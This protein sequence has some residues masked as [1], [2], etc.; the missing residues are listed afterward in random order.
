[1]KVSFRLLALLWLA[2]LQLFAQERYVLR[3]I[4]KDSTHLYGVAGVLLELYQH[5][6]L[7]TRDF[8]DNAG[9]FRLQV[10][11]PPPYQL[12]VKSGFNTGRMLTIS[13]LDTAITIK[14]PAAEIKAQEVVITAYR[15][16]SIQ[17]VTQTKLHEKAIKEWYYGADIPTLLQFT[18]SINAYS[19]AG[20]GIGYSYF[21]LRG[22]D[23][24]RINFSINGI[25]VNDPENQGVFFNNFADLASSARSLQVVR[26]VG[27]STNGTSAFGGAIHLHTKEPTETPA[28][29]FESGVGSFGSARMVVDYNTGRLAN[30]MAFTGRF[31]QIMSDG[32]RRHSGT[33]IQSY[34][35][36]GAKYGKRSTLRLHAF[37]GSTNSQLAYIGVTAEEMLR[38][39]RYNPITNG[40]KDA[41]NQHFFQLQYDLQLSDNLQLAISPYH[42]R[43]NAPKFQFTFPAEWQTPFSYFNMPPAI[44]GAD[45]I[46]TAGDMLVAY[47]LKQQLYGAYTNLRLSKERSESILGVHANTFHSDHF[48]QHQWGSI[49]PADIKPGHLVYFN[50]GVK[51]EFSVFNKTTHYLS[52]QWLIFGDLQ[53]R[54]AQF[55]YRERAMLYRPSY[56]S[57][58]PMQ[59]SFFNPKAGIRFFAPNGLSSYA[60]LGLTRREPTR[61]DYFQDDFATREGI[62]RDDIKPEQV[63]NLETGVHWSNAQWRI[64]ANLFYMQF[65]NQII[66]SGVLNQ[67]GTP[68]NTNVEHSYRQGV[69]LEL[70]YRPAPQWLL[71]HQSTWMQSR[72]KKITQYYFNEQFEQIPVSFTNI[73]PLLSPNV[74]AQQ[75]LRYYPS[76]DIWVEAISRY[77]SRQY[78]DNSMSNELSIPAYWVYEARLHVN[79]QQLIGASGLQL[80]LVCNN[81]L[82]RAYIPWGSVAAFS[83]T[84]DAEGKTSATPLYFPAATRNWFVT[85]SWRL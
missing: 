9:A 13:Q 76:A 29:G 5:D 57:V 49:L 70:S 39:R 17:P 40:E 74:I 84:I 73:T 28:F 53:W 35:L 41:F 10:K 58:E 65:Y 71:T 20:N 72:I 78:L 44:Q 42:V 14:L 4:V 25:P 59:W 51:N 55:S 79:L 37:G 66:G 32:Y 45:T 23:Q 38:D 21:R 63:A 68:I 82:N 43:G 8:T 7:L 80:S 26:G 18:P 3:G 16:T 19:D 54:M 81:V 48:M 50:T 83:N 62:R 67:F 77:V 15:P 47:R 36:S 27:T 56:G 22:I 33:A 75:G 31:S 61:F 24:T 46:I 1:M 30:D 6:K 69:E 2:S 60:S 52:D 34:Y 11:L 12:R 64:N 85:L